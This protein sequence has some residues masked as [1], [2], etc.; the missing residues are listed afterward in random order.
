MYVGKVPTVDEFQTSK[1]Y[2][3]RDTVL[4]AVGHDW[5]KPMEEGPWEIGFET[6][7]ITTGGI[8][9]PPYMFF[10]NN[11][12][13]IRS[14]EIKYW[15][16]GN[17]SMPR[18]LSVIKASG[19]G[20]EEWDST[21]YNMILVN[22]TKAFLDNHVSSESNPFFTYIALG[23]VH[24][25]NTPPYH[26]DDG[27]P[28]AKE[29]GTPHMD[30]LYEM[31]KVVGA[32]VEALDDRNLLE[33]TIIIFTSDNGGLNNETHSDEHGHLSNGPLRGAKGDL[34]EGGIRVPMTFRWDNGPIPKGET[35]SNLIGLNDLYRTICNLVGVEVPNNQAVDSMNFAKYLLNA[36]KD[37]GLRKWYGAWMY[38]SSR[39][40]REVMRYKEMKLV[41]SF[42]ND[43][44]ELFN[45]TD[46]I[47]ESKDISRENDD[48]VQKLFRKLRFEGPCY[49]KGGLFKV[50]T[51]NRKRNFAYKSCFWIRQRRTAKRCQ[52]FPEAKQHCRNSCAG[53]NSQY[54]AKDLHSEQKL[55]KIFSN[56]Y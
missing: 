49:D 53:R 47:S 33:D 35:R 37:A 40:I 44:Y 23:A 6:S 31:D 9:S 45:L 32:L 13:D 25:P 54:C 29:F 41:R 30:V 36:Q 1:F 24:L 8:Q 39:L 52:K 56:T 28:V 4:S 17:Y 51:K 3:K 48:T 50:E 46:D 7:Y 38:D 43:T 34:Y 11:T 22:E 27:S 5:S 10:R 16:E 19:E 14:G 15:N 21:A 12:L 26:F 55:F 20:S 2:A 42:Q 18:G